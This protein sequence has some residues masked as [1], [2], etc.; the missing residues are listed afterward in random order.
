MKN[1]I[2]FYNLTPS[3]FTSGLF[4]STPSIGLFNGCLEAGFEPLELRGFLFY[5]VRGQFSKLAWGISS[6]SVTTQP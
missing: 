5:G 2:I 1:L 3:A 4:S 6:P